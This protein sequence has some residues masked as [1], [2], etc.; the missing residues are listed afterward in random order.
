MC[1]FVF[2]KNDVLTV[3]SSHLKPFEVLISQW[4]CVQRETKARNPS[5]FALQAFSREI[6]P[7]SHF[8]IMWLVCSLSANKLQTQK[9]KNVVGCEQLFPCGEHC[10]TS[11][12]QLRRR[13]PL[14]SHYLF[15]WEWL[16][17]RGW[18][19]TGFSNI[20]KGSETLKL[21]CNLD[22]VR[23]SRVKWLKESHFI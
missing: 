1:L 4:T 5:L 17:K 16:F 13:Q 21:I 20:L 11:K 8:A 18:T 7:H 6:L 23:N 12:K 10:M 14:R 3:S 19:A 15:P 2:C 22:K 9:G